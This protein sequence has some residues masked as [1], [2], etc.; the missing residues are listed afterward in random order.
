MSLFVFTQCT[1]DKKEPIH[2]STNSLQDA[3]PSNSYFSVYENSNVKYSYIETSQLH[4]YSGN[5]DFDGDAILDRIMFFGN[6]G[7]HLQFSLLIH[8]SSI[9]TV[10]Y[11]SYL[12]TD[13]PLFEPIDSLLKLNKNNDVFPKFVVYDFN[14]DGKAD[15]YLNI[16]DGENISDKLKLIGIKSTKIILNYNEKRKA[17]DLNDYIPIKE[18]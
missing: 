13:M 3:K 7:A 16:V 1:N 2:V 8:L 17:F 9:D 11:F 4:D 6:N 15:V 10:F 5:W 18:Q 12:H 14:K